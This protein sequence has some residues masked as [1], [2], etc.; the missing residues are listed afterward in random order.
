M[1]ELAVQ[2]TPTMCMWHDDDGSLT[3]EKWLESLAFG[4]RQELEVQ[5]QF[6]HI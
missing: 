1:A 3:T 6:M 5:T 2:I 4:R